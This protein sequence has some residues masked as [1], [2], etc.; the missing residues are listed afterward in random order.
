MVLSH[1]FQYDKLNYLML[2]MVDPRVH[3]HVVPRYAEERHYRGM[4]FSDYGWP[5]A[6]DLARDNQVGDK[7]FGLLRGDLRAAWPA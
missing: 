2:M 3:F 5:G 6:P 7:V 1:L 4:E